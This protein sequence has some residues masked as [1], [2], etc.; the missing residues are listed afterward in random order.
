M[1]N[2]CRD[3]SFSPSYG[4]KWHTLTPLPYMWVTSELKHS[5]ENEPTAAATA[6]A[7][8]RASAGSHHGRD[9][10]RVGGPRTRCSPSS[11]P[12]SFFRSIG[13]ERESIAKAQAERAA[14]PPRVTGR[15]AALRSE[16]SRTDEVRRR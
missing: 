16:I 11:R 15:L 4:S 13:L 10:D 8:T 5:G 9:T 12:S 3:V 7:T 14:E 1:R 2:A 6:I